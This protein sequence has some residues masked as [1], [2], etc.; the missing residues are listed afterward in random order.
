M[1]VGYRTSPLIPALRRFVIVVEW[2]NAAEGSV[3]SPGKALVK[4]IMRLAVG[5]TARLT[6]V[7]SPLRAGSNHHARRRL[8]W[9]R[10]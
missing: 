9:L 3:S 10:W 1:V 5:A 4:V 2:I 6:W 8:W 7:E